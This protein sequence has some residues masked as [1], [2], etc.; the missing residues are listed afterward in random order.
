MTLYAP[1]AIFT[2]P[3]DTTAYTTGD[4][5]ANSTTAGSVTPLAFNVEGTR[6]RGRIVGVRLYKSSSTT[7]N[8]NFRLHLYAQSPTVTNGDNGAYAVASSLSWITFIGIDVSTGAD[9]GSSADVAQ[10]QGVSNSG[11]VFDCMVH[12]TAGTRYQPPMVIYGLLEALAGYSPASGETF[13]ITL[14]VSDI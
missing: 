8:A 1:A 2:R 3:A 12:G 14:E 13:K 9:V 5:V 7:L 11:I 6:G 4:L 10:R